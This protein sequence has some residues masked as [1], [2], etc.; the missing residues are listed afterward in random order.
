LRHPI[1]KDRRPLASSR[2]LALAAATLALGL[3]TGLAPLGANAQ[4]WPGRPIKFVVPSSPG[5]ATDTL[6][7]AL[8]S[9]LPDLWGQPVVVENRPGANQ[10]IGG[11]YVAK[12]PP[13][14]YTLLISDAATFVINPFL[15]RSLPYDPI[16]GFAPVTQLVQVPWVLGVNASLPVKSVAELIAYAKAHPGALSMGTFG[17][18]SSAH[19]GLEW[20]KRLTGTDIVHVPYKGSAPAAAALLTGEISMM[21]VTPLVLEQHARAGRVRLIAA[22]TEQRLPRIP[23]LPTIGEQGLPGYVVGTWFGMLAPAGT[24][25]EVVSRIAGDVAKVMNE[26][27]FREQNITGQWLIPIANSPQ[28]FATF[29]RRDYDY[30]KKMVETSG[31]RLD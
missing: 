1:P 20:F 5:G 28:A 15:Y 31:V 10:I 12:A 14:G 30:W 13:D 21:M 8:A 9:R 26:P 19:I 29:L 4:T 27:A 16:G 17:N 7:R 23:D 24:P 22:T 2:R 11:D 25:P 18:G 6:A 3:A